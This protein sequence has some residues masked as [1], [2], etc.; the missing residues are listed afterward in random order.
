MSR[1]LLGL[2]L[3]F[4]LRAE[5]VIKAS[6]KPTAPITV[7]VFSDF[8]CPACKQLHETSLRQVT[9]NYVNSGKVYLVHRE[10][11]LPM[12]KFSRQAAALAVAA[13]RIGKYDLVAD[14]LFRQQDS[15]S[16][17]GKVEEAIMGILSPG[18]MQKV[19]A[20]AK[21]PQTNATIEE[22]VALGKK[23]Q[24]NQTPTSV[25]T[26]KGQRY[27]VAGVVTYAILQRFFDL[28]LNPK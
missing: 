11:P 16:K 26:H 13:A 7:E 9:E 15:W 21:D 28:L 25:I 6:G 17:S 12:H 10:F 22:D 19:R 23:A 24:V 27:P 4:S 2:A 20:L 14:A 1:L 18:E 5:N 8:E 3:A